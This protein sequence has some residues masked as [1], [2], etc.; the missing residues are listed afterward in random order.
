MKATHKLKDINWQRVL[1]INFFVLFCVFSPFLPITGYV[2]GISMG[3]FLILS[4]IFMGLLY[5]LLL[6]VFGLG[7]L[8]SGVISL[9]SIKIPLSTPWMLVY[10]L[11]VT[12]IMS[13]IIIKLWQI[14]KRETD[15][16]ISNAGK[17]II[18]S[19]ETYKK[20]TDNYPDNLQ[21]LIPK[22]LEKMPRKK[23]PAFSQFKYDKKGE[24]Y[25]IQMK[26]M[27]DFFLSKVYVYNALD[28]DYPNDYLIQLS[29]HP[30]WE[31]YIDY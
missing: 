7:L 18:Q 19:L 26:V 29:G 30:G 13:F 12:I 16:V 11:P 23:F 20:D 24:R 14:E 27:N 21:E 4:A 5:I 3:M 2:H 9:K 25:I 10:S 17:Q 15:F 6:G 31:Y 1:T 8:L 28:G 22:Y